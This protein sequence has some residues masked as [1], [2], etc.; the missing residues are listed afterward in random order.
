MDLVRPAL[1]IVGTGVAAARLVQEVIDRAPGHF[2]IR[3]FGDEPHGTYDRPQLSRVL[4][5]F[6]ELDDLWIAPLEWYERHGALVHAGVRAE[7][8]DR[9]GRLVSGASGRV[10]EPYDL[11]VLATGSRAFLPPVEGIDR[12]GV[13]VFRTLEDCAR[14]ADRAG[15]SDRAVVLG[16][17]LLGL[18][19][20]RARARPAHPAGPL[21]PRGSPHAARLTARARGV[22]RDPGARGSDPRAT[23]R[24]RESH[25]RRAAAGPR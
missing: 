22:S 14:I 6:T 20:A 4:G 13:F 12:E 9:D 7:R 25:V 10:V 3:L 1:V 15:E 2:S 5:H 11:L 17:G 18:E 21:R 24:P 16:G 19:A 23:R 8:I